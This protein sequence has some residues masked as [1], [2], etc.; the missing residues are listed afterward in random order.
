MKKFTKILALAL[1][2]IMSLVVFA[3]CAPNADPVKAE[4]AL[5]E[6][7]Y[8]AGKDDTIVPGLLWVAG[9]KDVDCV[10]TGSLLVEGEGDEEDKLEHVTIV[11][12]ESEEAAEAAWEKMQDYAEKEDEDAEES[13]WTIKLSGAMIYYG[14]SAAIKAAR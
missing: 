9:I 7:G 11:Y 1:V 3:A 14:T 12:F 4:A 8:T 2:A 10:V 6:N 13:D 5:K